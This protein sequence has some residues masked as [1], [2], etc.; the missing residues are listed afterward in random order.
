MDNARLLKWISWLAAGDSVYFFV[1]NFVLLLLN[2]SHPG[3]VLYSLPVVFVGIA[4]T[5]TTAAL[6][7]LVRRAAELQKQSDLTI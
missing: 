1:G 3:I 4:V 7:H 2:M 5:V 6:S